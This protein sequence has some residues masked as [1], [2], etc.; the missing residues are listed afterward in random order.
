MRLCFLGVALAAPEMGSF[1]AHPIGGLGTIALT[2]RDEDARVYGENLVKQSR[3]ISGVHDSTAML[4]PT[5]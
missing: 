2:T 1:Q 5:E 3:I 4:K